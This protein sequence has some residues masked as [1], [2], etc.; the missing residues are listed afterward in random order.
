MAVTLPMENPLTV[1]LVS[2]LA[3]KR[4]NADKKI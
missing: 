3:D 2:L 1:F 4:Q